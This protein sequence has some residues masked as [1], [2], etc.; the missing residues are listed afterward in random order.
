LAGAGAESP[1][2][3]PAVVRTTGGLEAARHL[4]NRRERERP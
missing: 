1:A 3:T 2:V 4:G